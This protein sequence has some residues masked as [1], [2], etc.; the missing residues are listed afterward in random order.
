MNELDRMHCAVPEPHPHHAWII[1]GEPGVYWCTGEAL[2]APLPSDDFTE[3]NEPVDWSNIRMEIK[4]NDVMGVIDE[5]DSVAIKQEIHEALEEL[6]HE[7]ADAEAERYDTREGVLREAIDLITGDRNAV[8]GPPTID[9]KRTAKALS[10]LGFRFVYA[11]SEI[12][13]MPLELDAHHVAMIMIQLKLSRLMWSPGK[14]D[15]WVDIAGYAGCG[16][17]CAEEEFDSE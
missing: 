7:Q 8:Y 11:D 3:D 13:V 6:E 15:S 9:F 12:G 5:R 14:R 4:A 1:R 17:E 16:Y 2:A 10:A